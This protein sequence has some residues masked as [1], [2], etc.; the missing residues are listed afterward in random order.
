MEQKIRCIY[1]KK[2]CFHICNKTVIKNSFYCCHHIHSKKKH[3]CKIFFNVLEDRHELTFNNIYNLY[4]YIVEN[5]SEN[6]DIF[7]NIMFIDLLKMVPID[8]LSSIYKDYI[9]KFNITA[10]KTAKPPAK[11]SIY[12][13]IY[14]LN[15]NT[16]LFSKKCN[17]NRLIEFQNIVRYKLLSI[18]NTS[19]FNGYLNDTD[20]FSLQDVSEIHPRKLFTVKDIKGAYAFDIVE[21]EYF[22]RKCVNDN[23][24]PYNPYTREAFSD[25]IIW[26]LNRQIEYNNIIKKSDECLWTTDM[27]AYTD[28]SIEIERR[29]FYNNPEWF[30]KMSQ[31]DFLKC[32][33]LF[34]D[35]SS[36]IEDS[37][38]YFVNICA[39]SSQH[40]Q[41]FTYDFCKECIKMFNECNDDLYILCCNFMKSLAL[42]SNDFYNN[43]PDWLATYETTSYISNLSNFTSIISSLINNNNINNINIPSNNLTYEEYDYAS[44]ATLSTSNNYAAVAAAT[45]YNSVGDDLMNDVSGSGGSGGSSSDDNSIL[46]TNIEIS[47][48]PTSGTSAISTINPSNNFLLYYYVEYM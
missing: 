23:V 42:C 15:K 30:K 17:T 45:A 10:V 18:D 1:R 3:L 29:G 39:S 13:N 40:S 48:I 28:L 32:I 47:D 41:S 27:N 31:K 11:P 22:V 7:I 4:K 38:R 25:K 9:N 16:Y 46:N 35:F 24:A 36:N 2:K 43:I 14:L 34:R 44:L 19:I 20:V 12:A 6:D 26:R 21:L 37:K 8:K 5:T 33:K